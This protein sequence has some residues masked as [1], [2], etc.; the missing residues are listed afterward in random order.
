MKKII[1]T[2][3]DENFV[4]LLNSLLG[5]LQQWHEPVSDAIGV[6]D[7]GL[8][9]ETRKALESR[10]DH[11][12]QADWDVD[13]PE[14]IRA[15]RPHY[16]ARTGRPF[17]PRYFPGYDLYLWLDADTWLQERHVIEWFYQAAAGG[18]MAIVPSEDRCFRYT[19]R[20]LTYRRQQLF[21]HFGEAGARLYDNVM[22]KRSEHLYYN[23]GAFC[24]GH[25]APH[26]KS[27]GDNFRS[28]AG[29]LA[30]TVSDQS[31]MNYSVWTDSLPVYPLPALCN[32]LCHYSVPVWDPSRK[33]FCEPLIP[34]R[35]IGILH[36][37]GGA[38]NFRV[39]MRT[40]SGFCETNLLFD[41]ERA[42]L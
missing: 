42:R 37:T 10:V 9:S 26:W 32:W 31:V 41:P 8:S 13:L 23:S 17:L 28:V 33:K 3:S 16:R 25:D 21:E 30:G 15:A 40:A 5:S 14:A 12:V 39:K 22:L 20:S 1:V 36:M 38:K 34:H 6:L 7:V 11:V 29:H 18:A 19:N 2:A 35:P 24:L 4:P 27:W